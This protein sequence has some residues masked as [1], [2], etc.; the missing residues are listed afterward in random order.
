MYISAYT[1]T[2]VDATNLRDV[3]KHHRSLKQAQ[4]E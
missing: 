3:I 4:N 1:I 2:A